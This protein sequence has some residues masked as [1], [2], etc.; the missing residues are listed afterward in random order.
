[1]TSN[2]GAAFG[3][4]KFG[5]VLDIEPIFSLAGPS[6][7]VQPSPDHV[8]R[9]LD[10]DE[11]MASHSWVEKERN[12]SH[13]DCKRTALLSSADCRAE[14]L[15]LASACFLTN[16]RLSSSNHLPSFQGRSSWIVVR[17]IMSHYGTFSRAGRASRQHE[18]RTVNSSAGRS[19]RMGSE[20]A[21]G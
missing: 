13:A 9:A 2:G 3:P 21:A 5:R 6:L 11:R 8:A 16:R 10:A 20:R 14:A 7:M 19:G 4:R 15:Q 12:V 17:G 1:M 18:L